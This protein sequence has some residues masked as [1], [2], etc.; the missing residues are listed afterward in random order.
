MSATLRPLRKDEY[1]DWLA[2]TKDGY[3]RSMIDAGGVPEEIARTKAEHDHATLLPEGL[4]TKDHFIFAVEA[5]GEVVGSLWLAN[6]DG[7]DLGPSMFVYALAI[8]EAHRGRGFGRDA[9]Q[10]AEGEARSHGLG[11]ITLN[12]FGGNAVARGLYTSLGYQEQA[13]FMRKEM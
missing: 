13:V 12:V 2:R 1:E 3:A 7:G 4:A 9:M 10:L 11:S 6:R 8:D 5:G